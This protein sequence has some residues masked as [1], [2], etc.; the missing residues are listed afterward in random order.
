MIEE[1]DAIPTLAISKPRVGIVGEI[2]VKF[3]PTA[4]NHLVELLEA[5]GAEA[6]VPDLMDFMFYCFYNQLYKAENLGTSKK[7]AQISKLG[8]KAIE[9]LLKRI[10]GGNEESP[11]KISYAASLRE[12]NSIQKL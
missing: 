10:N 2:L 12:G 9:M 5:E 8:I 6:V 7:G 4:N 11:Q 3:S 1:F